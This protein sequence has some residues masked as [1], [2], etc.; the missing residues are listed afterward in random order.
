MWFV[1]LV[2]FITHSWDFV[3]LLL[4]YITLACVDLCA[5]LVTVTVLS[6]PCWWRRS[7]LREAVIV[8]TVSSALTKW[9]WVAL[10]NSTLFLYIYI[11]MLFSSVCMSR[12]FTL[13]Y[14]HALKIPKH[15]LLLH[16]LAYLSMFSK[17]L[18]PKYMMHSCRHSLFSSL[19][20]LWDFGY[21]A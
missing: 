15:P 16:S 10:L 2:F 1:P 11:Q 12:Y 21:L 18:M 20:Q 6:P 14:F 17:L 5:L 4:F 13:L 7:E 3:S 8:S 19:N 9:N